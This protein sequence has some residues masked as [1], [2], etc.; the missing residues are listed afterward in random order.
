MSAR[1]PRNVHVLPLLSLPILAALASGAAAQSEALAARSAQGELLAYTTSDRAV[2][3]VGPGDHAATI[4]LEPGSRLAA[5][6][7]LDQG[8]LAVSETAMPAGGRQLRAFLGDL[9]EVHELALPSNREGA[10]ATGPVPLVGGGSF[11]GLAWL[12]GDG[13]RSLR[14]RAAAWDGQG[15]QAVERVSSQGPGSQTALTGVV[16]ADGSWLLVWSRF[17]GEDTE[18]VWSQRR[19]G[20]WSPPAPVSADNRVPDVLPALLATPDGALLAWSRYDGNDYRLLL[21]RFTGQGF[22]A[23]AMIGPAGSFEP[24]FVTSQ[25]RTLLLYAAA[26]PRRWEVLELAGDGAVRGKA[27]VARSGEN[28]PLLAL[29][30]ATREVVLRW[31]LAE[32]ELRATL[33]ATLQGVP[34]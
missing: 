11:R 2:R 31:P 3:V 28:R 33:R 6:T 10:L 21:A 27:A 20:A 1:L 18:L 12:E 13:D 22:E 34:R 5:F 19:D 23:E 15:L 8:W 30:P 26:V 24:G 7:A 17:D 25:G 32:R 14:V 16:L 9:G 4:A 29:D